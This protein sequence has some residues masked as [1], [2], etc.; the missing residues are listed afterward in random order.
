MECFCITQHGLSLTVI[1]SQPVTRRS[2]T[3]LYFD[4][5]FQRVSPV[6]QVSAHDMTKVNIFSRIKKVKVTF[7]DFTVNSSLKRFFEHVDPLPVAL[8]FIVV[9]AIF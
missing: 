9:F 6:F 5:D 4:T 3:H 2:E 7:F 1:F 8:S